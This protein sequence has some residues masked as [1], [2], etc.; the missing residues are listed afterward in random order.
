MA[1][2]RKP[3]KRDGGKSWTL[4]SQDATKKYSFARLGFSQFAFS[5]SNPNLVV[6]ATGSASEGIVEGLE[7][8]ITVNRGLNYSTDAGASWRRAAVT[9]SGLLT[10]PASATSVVYNSAA[11]RFYAAIRFH[12]IYSSS[13]AINWTRL[14]VQPGPALIQSACPPQTATPSGCPIYRGEIAVVPQRPGQAGLGEMYV[15][16]VDAADSDQ[17]I[18]KNI[19]GGASW[20]QVDDS[21]ITNCGDFFDGCGTE[22]GGH[23]LA[24]AAV[25]NGTATDLYAGAVNLYKCKITNASPNCSG[26]G[27]N[28]FLN[29]TQAYGCS[30]IARVHPNQHAIAFQVA[31]GTAPLYL[32]NDGGVYRVLDGFTGLT[33]GTCGLSNI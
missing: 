13:D 3:A 11:A 1:C 31:N 15:W 4:I 23:N 25:A 20:S 2:T 9:D 17:G 28:T 7:N 21:G 12:G 24:L 18:W 10:D 30:D 27:T 14:A 32:A 19:D 26:N 5:T 33:T 29:L 16:F 6:A 8:P 22:Q